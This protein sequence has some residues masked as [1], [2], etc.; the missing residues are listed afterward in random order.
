MTRNKTHRRLE[1]RFT[2]PPAKTPLKRFAVPFPSKQAWWYLL[3]VVRLLQVADG[4]DPLPQ[5]QRDGG[6]V[7]R[8]G[9]G[10][11]VEGNQVRRLNHRPAVRLQVDHHQLLLHQHHQGTGVACRRTRR[12]DWE[13]LSRVVVV[14][15]QKTPSPTPAGA[16]CGC[17][18]H[19]KSLIHSLHHTQL[20]LSCTGSASP[21]TFTTT[22]C[23]TTSANLSKLQTHLFSPDK[24]QR[25]ICSFYF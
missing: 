24:L 23:N 15:Q 20:T 5:F 17:L 14:S 19:H 2:T 25:F 1:T 21:A 6:H 8:A 12:R 18:C 9:D 3:G 7:V 11:A 10:R 22:T 16:E 13:T 4:Q